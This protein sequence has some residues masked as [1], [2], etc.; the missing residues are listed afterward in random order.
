MG[1]NTELLMKIVPSGATAIAAECSLA[2]TP[3]DQ[4]MEGFEAGRFFQIKDFNFSA[5][6]KDDSG[7]AP[8]E[9]SAGAGRGSGPAGPGGSYRP[10][11]LLAMP[12]VS[13]TATTRVAMARMMQASE[14]QAH[15]PRQ[16]ARPLGTPA[17]DATKDKPP[18]AKFAKWRAARGANA[19]ATY[20][21]EVQPITFTRTMDQASTALV[22][23]LFDSRSL[24]S[25][26]IVRR[27]DTGSGAKAYLRLDFTDVLITGIDWDD[28]DLI[29][30]KFRF[31]CREVQVRFRPQ[32]SDGSLGAA[33]SG[34]WPLP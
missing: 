13:H 1:D 28:D 6:L 26:S 17:A 29:E 4:L 10:G 8:G 11:A 15:G 27:V 2:I 24:T 23:A 30:E 5:G 32:N 34:R 25:A 16:A 12:A 7:A 9:A 22:Q 19:G 18:K 20:P 3:G 14:A 31:I 21:L 33:I